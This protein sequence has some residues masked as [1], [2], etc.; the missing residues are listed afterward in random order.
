[1]AERQ[2]SLRCR[3]CN[4]LMISSLDENSCL[5][6]GNVDYGPDF[7]PLE[8]TVAEARRLERS[9]TEGERGLRSPYHRNDDADDLARSKGR[10]SYLH[11]APAID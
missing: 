8:L 9:E 7:K 3:R 6:C 1:M 11:R 4:G 2:V 10:P 5:L